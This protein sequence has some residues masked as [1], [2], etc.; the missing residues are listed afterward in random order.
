[1]A[2]DYKPDVTAERYLK[3]ECEFSIK[4]EE[5]FERHI[6]RLHL[7]TLR[8]IDYEPFWFSYKPSWLENRKIEAQVSVVS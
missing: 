4:T 1:M 5:A 6:K 3:M 2:I 8:I 7:K